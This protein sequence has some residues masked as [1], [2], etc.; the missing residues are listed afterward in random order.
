[1]NRCRFYQTL[2]QRSRSSKGV[3]GPKRCFYSERETDLQNIKPL[4]ESPSPFFG[5]VKRFINL[6]AFIRANIGAFIRTGAKALFSTGSFLNRLFYFRN[7]SERFPLTENSFAFYE[8]T[9]KVAKK[10]SHRHIVFSFWISTYS[11]TCLVC[12]TSSIPTIGT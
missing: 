9:S 11:K 10:G 2:K 5:F 4:R 8:P 1:M 3:F 12:D 7:G 6:K